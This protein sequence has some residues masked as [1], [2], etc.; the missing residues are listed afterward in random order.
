MLPRIKILTFNCL[1]LSIFLT[2]LPEACS[3]SL[4]SSL[5]FFTLYIA[6][7]PPSGFEVSVCTHVNIFVLIFVILTFT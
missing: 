1:G 6:L 4:G 5:Q 3:S 2:E 7:L